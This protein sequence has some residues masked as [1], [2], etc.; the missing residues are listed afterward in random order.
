MTEKRVLW[1]IYILLLAVLLPHTAWAFN[2]FEPAGKWYVAWAAAFAFESMIAMLTHKLSQHIEHTCRY[3]KWYKRYTARYVNAYAIGLL[4]AVGVSTLANLAHSVEFGGDLVI[5]ARYGIPFG[6]Y[7]VAFGA[8]LPVASL[9]FASVLSNEADTEQEAN[10]EM[11]ALRSTIREIRRQVRDTEERANTA[12]QR[13]GAMGDLF[14]KLSGDDKRN[15]ILAA[16]ELW[17]GLTGAAIAVIGD[18]SPSYTSEVINEGR[19]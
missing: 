13:F 3:K 6:V 16:R 18:C 10:E 1:A 17:P 7:A 8:I 15:R 11:V 12:E 5:F 9:V 2:N 19:K 4:L 14:V